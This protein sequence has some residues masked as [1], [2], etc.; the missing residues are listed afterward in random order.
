MEELQ[1][2][3][4]KFLFTRI[5]SITVVYAIV[6]LIAYQVPAYHSNPYLTRGLPI[7][8][9]F[10][11]VF[12]ASSMIQLPLQLFRQMKKVTIALTIARV[13]QLI[14]L[15]ALIRWIAPGMGGNDMPIRLFVAIMSSVLISGIAQLIYTRY[16][17]S[18]HL[19]IKLIPDRKFT[20]DITRRNAAYGLAYF[21]SSMHT[22][23]IS[24]II[25]LIYPTIGNNPEQ[26]IRKLPLGIIVVLIIIPSSIGNSMIH[27]IAD[28]TDTAKRQAIGGLIT[29]MTWVG[30]LIIAACIAF[31]PQVIGLVGGPEYLTTPQHIG[32]DFLLPWL[33]I[34]LVGS[35]IKQ[36]FNYLFLAIHRQ[37]ILLTING[38]GILIGL[39]FAIRAIGQR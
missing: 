4:S 1:T 28:A 31:A 5:V 23:A 18:K 10:S 35:F 13:A 36:C 20:W 14:V 27:K 22:L 25:G 8:A 12:M 17:T 38:V 29:L 30:G 7:G 2:E 16:E 37:N 32:A 34:I 21:L 3:Y 6:L 15:A 9:L 26:G 19:A 39:P 33:A 24:V 11:A